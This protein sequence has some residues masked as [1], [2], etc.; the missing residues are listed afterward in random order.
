MEDRNCKR[1]L[2]ISCTTLTIFQHFVDKDSA[3]LQG[4][5]SIGLQAD[6]RDLIKFESIDSQNSK[7][8]HVRS[9]LEKMFRSAKKNV[10]QRTLRSGQ[11]SLTQR[12]VNQVRRSL[13]GIDMGV[14]FRARERERSISSW[15]TSEPLYQAWLST[16]IA[17]DPNSSYLW[18]KGGPGL[19]KTNASLAAIQHLAVTSMDHQIGVTSDQNGTFVAYFLCEWTS[20]CSTAEEILKSLITQLINQDESLA[21]HGARWFVSNPRYRGPSYIEKQPVNEEMGAAGAKATATVDNLWKCLQEMVDD[22]AVHSVHFIINNMHVLE[23]GGSTTALLS[24]LRD[25][26]LSLED[27]PPADRRVKWLITSRGDRHICDFL[28]SGGIS[29]I[30]LENDH[31]YG[32]K[33]RQA[34]QR[35]AKDVVHQLRSDKQ[36]SYDLAWYVRNSID[37]QSEDETWIDILCTL[38]RAMPST[39]TDLTIRKWLRE[40]SSYNTNKLIDHA[41][42]TVRTARGSAFRSEFD[43]NA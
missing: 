20:G 8:L 5:F 11:N 21:Q 1:Y 10:R 36:Y 9:E 32:T 42:N 22:P 33:V 12:T 31:E 13:E 30:D 28:K 39:S 16:Y 7:F 41:W 27:Q 38:L 19:G 40:V 29:V 35:H 4:A 26:A 3:V 43:A 37:S 2:S 18:L 23:S 15:L 17:P 24:K 14:K 34:R 25:H 6:H